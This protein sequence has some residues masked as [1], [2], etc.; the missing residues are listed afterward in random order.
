MAENTEVIPVQNLLEEVTQEKLVLSL[1]K[2]KVK[3]RFAKR[4]SRSVSTNKAD[5]TIYHLASRNIIPARD[6]NG[7]YKTPFDRL[8]PK[9][10]A[11]IEDTLGICL[12]KFRHIENSYF[13]TFEKILKKTKI[14]IKDN[15]IELD[16]SD[17]Q[18]WVD[19]KIIAEQPYVAASEKEVRPNI[20]LFYIDDESV[21]VRDKAASIRSKVK[22]QSAIMT[23]D[24]NAKMYLLLVHQHSFNKDHARVSN[25][26]I[27]KSMSHEAVDVALYTLME[28]VKCKNNLVTLLEMKEREPE[29]Y[30]CYTLLI[31]GLMNGQVVVTTQGFSLVTGAPLSNTFDNCIAL[32][33]DPKG[34]SVKAQLATLTSPHLKLTT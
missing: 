13:R 28:D 26:T 32:L 23:A 12:S 22:L 33:N 11:Q 29:K 19:Y 25:L 7:N 34:A 2:K 15:Y 1:P 4:D 14:D 6:N 21:S 16:L 31:A 17:L 8:D 27:N 20:H 24:Y 3:I 30:F 5:E 18:Q 10:V 9:V